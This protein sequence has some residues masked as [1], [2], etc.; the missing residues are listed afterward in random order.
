MSANRRTQRSVRVTVAGCLLLV[1]AVW[2]VG[3]VATGVWVPVAALGGLVCGGVA[4]RIVCSEV[5]AT[6]REAARGRA[7]QARDF[8]T[9]LSRVRAEHRQVLTETTALAVSRGRRVVELTGL[10]RVADRRADEAERRLEREAKRADDAQA[11]M[12]ELLD[13]V[14]AQSTALSLDRGGVDDLDE[15]PTVVDLLAW[16]DGVSRATRDRELRRQA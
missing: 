1:A 6:R 8:G 14:L 11:R 5:A 16:E 7:E 4:T 3:A 2:V 13:D 10:L 15:L 9:A 12:S